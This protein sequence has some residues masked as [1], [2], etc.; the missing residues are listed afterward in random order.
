LARFGWPVS[1]VDYTLGWPA[2]LASGS[3]RP[4]PRTIAFEWEDGPMDGIEGT[5]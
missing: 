3:L 5:R 1:P 2:R 4:S